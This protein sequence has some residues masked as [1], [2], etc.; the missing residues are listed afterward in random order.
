MLEAT[1]S[2]RQ[3]GRKL[4][5]SS[6]EDNRVAVPS[7][8]ITSTFNFV[9]KI[10]ACNDSNALFYFILFLILPSSALCLSNRSASFR[11]ASASHMQFLFSRLVLKEELFTVPRFVL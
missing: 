11:I 3:N 1:D 5:C 9:G 10:V 7:A 4:L 2:C 8:L 6:D